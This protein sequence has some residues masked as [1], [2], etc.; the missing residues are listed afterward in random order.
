[1]I[2]KAIIANPN[3]PIAMATLKNI[4]LKNA[5]NETKKQ[6]SQTI[7]ESTFIHSKRPDAVN[8]NTK[9]PSLPEEEGDDE[10]GC[11]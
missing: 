11:I 3:D 2:Q 7:P 8:G 9:N 4:L 1:M 6:T 10:M 5:L